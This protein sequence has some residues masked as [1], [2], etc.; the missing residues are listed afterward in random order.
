MSNLDKLIYLGD[1]IEP[2]RHFQGV[3][4][5]R[6]LSQK[7]LDD[8]FKKGYNYS[9]SYV[10]KKGKLLHPLTVKIWNSLIVGDKKDEGWL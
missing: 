5:L 8:A 6:E 2:A 9:L 1:M 3:E 7:N 4:E 10:L